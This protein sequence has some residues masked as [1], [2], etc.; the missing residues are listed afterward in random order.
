MRSKI[1]VHMN[2]YIYKACIYIYSI[3]PLEFIE[4]HASLDR[5]PEQG[6]NTLKLFDTVDPRVSL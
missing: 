1:N 2:I 5:N 3:N 6:Y 4:T